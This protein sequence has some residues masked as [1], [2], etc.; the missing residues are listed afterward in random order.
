MASFK[1]LNEFF[2][3][4]D[5]SDSFG[6]PVEFTFMNRIDVNKDG[7]ISSDM[8]DDRDNYPDQEFE[9]D[10][11]FLFTVTDADE[12]YEELDEVLNNPVNKAKLPK[13]PGTYSIT[14]TI[15]AD[16]QIQ[17]IETIDSDFDYWEE[18]GGGSDEYYESEYDLSN[19]Y[20]VVDWKNATIKDVKISMTENI[21]VS[22]YGHYMDKYRSELNQKY[23][24][25][26]CPVIVTGDPMKHTQYAI[27]DKYG[28]WYD[29]YKYSDKLEVI[30]SGKAFKC[31]DLHEVIKTIEREYK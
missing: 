21:S 20:A 2:S 28:N 19:A 3:D 30:I 17:D 23:A 31:K 10:D 6:E 22:E 27:K 1:Y 18:P 5:I 29:V 24:T 7:S 8:Y 14:A 9:Y 25:E 12:V 11:E 4:Y 13:E 16:Y 15:V 26:F